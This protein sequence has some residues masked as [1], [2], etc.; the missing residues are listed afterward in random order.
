MIYLDTSAL[1][2]L[3][4][5]ES[6]SERVQEIIENQDDPLPIWEVQEMELINALRL[7]VFWKS[8]TA[9][10]S[11]EQIN[12]FMERRKKG[13]YFFPDIDRSALLNDF[14]RLAESTPKIGCRTLDVLHVACA[15]QLNVSK[16]VSYD[17]RQ[18]VLAK[19]AGLPVTD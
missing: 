10:Q 19:A 9:R 13:V 15:H 4:I 17:E 1:I 5:R 16:F 18:R 3:Y 12:L 8:L 2:K 7:Q 11:R 14:H 6:G